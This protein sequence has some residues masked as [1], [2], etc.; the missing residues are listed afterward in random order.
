MKSQRTFGWIQNPASTMTLQRVVAIFD[1]Q[2]EVTEW[3]LNE[4]IPLLEA[5][6]MLHSVEEWKNYASIIQSGKPIP[7]SILK[8]KGCGNGERRNA[9]CSGIVQAVIDAQ[10]YVEVEFNGVKSKIR[11][12][13]TDDWTADGFLRW[14]ISV[15]FIDYDQETDTCK[16]SDLGRRFIMA[17]GEAFN[18]VLGEAYLSYPPA[19]RVLQLLSSGEHLTKFEIGRNLG[20]TSEAGFTSFPQ[21][22][23]VQAYNEHPEDRT[24]IRNNYEGSSDKYAR[25]ICSWLNEIGWVSI[26]EKQVSEKCG[27]KEYSCSISQA[28]TIT[29][30]GIANYKRA[31]GKSSFAQIPKRVFFSMLSTKSSDRDY[32]RLRRALILKYTEKEYRSLDQIKQFL[33]S[34]GLTEDIATV[35][36][37]LQGLVNIGLNYAMKSGCYRLADKIHCLQIPQQEKTT[38]KG[39]ISVIK[40]RIRPVLKNVNPKYLVLIDLSLDG[41]ANLEFEI[42]TLDLLTNELDFKG[43]H[44]GGSRKPDG[45]IYYDT[46]G[47][48]IDNKA[49]SKGYALPRHQIDEMV[50]YLQENNERR[51]DINPSKWW[52][53]FGNYVS[54]FNYAFISSFFTGQFLP[55]LQEIKNRTGINGAVLDIE[56]LLYVAEA[57]KREELS[58]HDFFKL[59]EQNDN[60]VFRLNP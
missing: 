25:M 46:N 56:N 6:G 26:S 34:H 58:Y 21:N 28:Y 3:L 10:K 2:S 50:R 29:A 16:I 33:A 38:G 60:I 18:N 55:R 24:I 11:K 37:D 36:D 14:G 31:A 8:G 7:Y 12:P 17:D 15:G 1:C 52:N 42:Q 51:E 30:L 44:L 49:Y 13:Y 57:L 19:C 39:A 41:K 20:F 27:G 22:I 40:D 53:E 54:H 9:K 23:W 32:L 4:R 45:I 5:N 59:F 48:I 47:L 35:K 43:K